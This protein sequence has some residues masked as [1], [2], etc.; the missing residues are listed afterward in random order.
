MLSPG[1]ERSRGQVPLMTNEGEATEV[2]ARAEAL[3]GEVG[4]AVLRVG[5]GVGVA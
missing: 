3:F 5:G 1:K 2:R 4:G